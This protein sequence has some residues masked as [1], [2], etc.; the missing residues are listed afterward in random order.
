MDDGE[1]ERRRKLELTGIVVRSFR[2]MR[3]R[4]SELGSTSGS[5]RCSRSTGSGM[6]SGV[7]GCRRRPEGAAE[8]HRGVALGEKKCR[9]IEVVG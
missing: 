6:G 3:V 7:G 1:A 5:R 2:C 8:V 4:L 9:G